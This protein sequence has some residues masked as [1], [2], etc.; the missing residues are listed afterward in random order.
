M[1]AELLLYDPR[2]KVYLYRYKILIV[3]KEIVMMLYT[4][5]IKYVYITPDWN[6]TGKGTYLK[7]R[8]KSRLILKT[9]QNDPRL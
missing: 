8:T 3:N 6:G 1:G 5:M 2:I 9:W 7:T 4:C